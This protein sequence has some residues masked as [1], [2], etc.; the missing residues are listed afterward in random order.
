MAQ[1]T[2]PAVLPL[3]VLPVNSVLFPSLILSLQIARPDSIALLKA[4]LRVSL[5]LDNL[6]R[7]REA[8]L[9]ALGRR[10]DGRWRRVRGCSL[11]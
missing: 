10:A 2:I 11:A 1:H 9:G 5:C 6:E 7:H 4:L 3:I 8:L